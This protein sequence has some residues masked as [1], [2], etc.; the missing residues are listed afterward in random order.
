MRGAAAHCGAQEPDPPDDDE[1]EEG[2]GAEAG[3]KTR[4]LA[5]GALVTF[6]ACA[7]SRRQS[8]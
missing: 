3:T 5:G 4:A 6:S 8:K 1:E 2:E 7:L